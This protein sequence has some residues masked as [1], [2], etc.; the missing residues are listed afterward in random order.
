MLEI[1]QKSSPNRERGWTSK[2]PPFKL[3]FPSIP[4]QKT[5]SVFCGE[6]ERYS[7]KIEER[8]S[9]EGMHGSLQLDQ[10]LFRLQWLFK[11]TCQRREDLWC[12]RAQKGISF[13]SVLPKTQKSAFQTNHKIHKIM[14]KCSIKNLITSTCNCSVDRCPWKLDLCASDKAPRINA[15][16]I[17]LLRCVSITGRQKSHNFNINAFHV[18]ALFPC[19]CFEKGF[20]MEKSSARKSSPALFCGV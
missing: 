12:L 2:H 18:K 20:I 4:W 17:V 1:F 5:L 11:K 19:T 15:P 8:Q 14:K 10:N 6:L 13:P 7:S 9:W 16:I 3:D